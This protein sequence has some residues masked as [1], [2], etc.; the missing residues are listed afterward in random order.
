MSRPTWSHSARC[1]SGGKCVSCDTRYE[2]R[3]LP[4]SSSRKRLGC[5]LHCITLSLPV[6][7]LSLKGTSNG[8]VVSLLRVDA[9][10][11]LLASESNRALLPT[12][13][14]ARVEQASPQEDPKKAILS[15]QTLL[16]SEDDDLPVEEVQPKQQSLP[17][18]DLDS[19]NP[20]PPLSSK[21]CISLSRCTSDVSD[22]TYDRHANRSRHLETLVFD[23][24]LLGKGTSDGAPLFSADE[25][26]GGYGRQEGRVEEA[27][28]EELALR[29]DDEGEEGGD[30]GEDC[31][32]HLAVLDD[33]QAGRSIAREGGEGPK[34]RG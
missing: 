34:A 12:S 32:A 19:A 7:V 27:Q 18:V 28:R 21:V 25:V 8:L 14:A 2:E 16:A 20:Q 1:P 10:A 23:I 11:C 15:V 22:E 9:N 3:R 24:P 31:D 26:Y 5:R 17:C 33:A 4:L 30:H 29:W 6:G 13:H